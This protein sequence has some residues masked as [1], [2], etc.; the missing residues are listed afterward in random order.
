[1]GHEESKG[2][3]ER[4]TQQGVG[5]NRPQDPL[6]KRASCDLAEAEMRVGKELQPQVSMVL[7]IVET[8]TRQIIEK[9]S[10]KLTQAS[11]VFNSNKIIITGFCKAN[12]KNDY[13]KVK[14]ECQH[15]LTGYGIMCDVKD[16]DPVSLLVDGTK[17]DVIVTIR[18]AQVLGSAGYFMDD[19]DAVL[20]LQDHQWI[21][22]V[23]FNKQGGEMRGCKHCGLH[24]ESP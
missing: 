8:N 21:T 22:G 14:E 5:T 15:L 1:M 20:V 19:E 23:G 9:E 2:N 12:L 17:C 13:E 16:I 18:A 7:D 11:R 24:L 3:M 4:A 6:V 10:G